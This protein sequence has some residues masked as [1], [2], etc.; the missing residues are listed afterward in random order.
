[1]RRGVGGSTLVYAGAWIRP[2]RA[3]F[4]RLLPSVDY[5]EL[6]RVHYPRAARMA[7]IAPIP[8]DVLAHPNYRAVPGPGQPRRADHWR[9]PNALTGMWCGPGW[10]AARCPR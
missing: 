4:S 6:D 9:L 8:D 7:G 1:M 2:D 3:V 5:T 10:P